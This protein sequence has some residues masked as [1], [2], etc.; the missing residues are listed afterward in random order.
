MSAINKNAITITTIEGRPCWVKGRRAIFH[1]WS[2][3]A[4]PVNPYGKG[5]PSDDRLQK[6]SVHGIVEYEDGTVER[7]WPSAI[8]FADSAE[9]FA[10]FDWVGMEDRRDALPYDLAP[11][12]DEDGKIKMLSADEA[13]AILERCKTCTHKGR[14]FDTSCLYCKAGDRYEPKEGQA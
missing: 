8:Q 12:P 6:W 9:K 2:D 3:S 14:L 1:R 7:E 10:A 13:R 5:D 11:D 4:R